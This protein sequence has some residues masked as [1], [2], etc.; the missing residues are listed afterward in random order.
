MTRHCV[1]LIDDHDH[2]RFD[3]R[4]VLEGQGH[5]VEEADD[6]LDGVCKRGGKSLARCGFRHENYPS[7]VGNK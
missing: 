3:L 1:L 6:G 4:R 2:V 7:L 5:A